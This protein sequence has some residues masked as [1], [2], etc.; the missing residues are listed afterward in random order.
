MWTDFFPLHSLRVPTSCS[1]RRLVPKAPDQAFVEARPGYQTRSMW[2]KKQHVE[3]R[4]G[5]NFFLQLPNSSI[6]SA[7]Y[8]FLYHVSSHHFIL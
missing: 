1:C 6:Q 3:I 7:E 8:I 2:V 5:L 4:F